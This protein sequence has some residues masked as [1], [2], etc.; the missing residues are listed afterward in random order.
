MANVNPVEIGPENKLVP[1]GVS[2]AEI[3]EP[4]DLFESCPDAVVVLDSA[5]TR[6]LGTNLQFLQLVGRDLTTWQGSPFHLLDCIHPDDH[7]VLM[8]GAA[9]AGTEWQ[10]SSSLRLI[11][12][13]N[14]VIPIE[15]HA[16][17]IGTESG[18][19]WIYFFRRVEE[20]RILE[21]RLKEEIEL[22]KR[23]TVEA[24]KSSLRIYQVTEK[25]RATPKL[26]TFLLDVQNEND[27]FE[28]ATEFL[29][30]EGLNYQEV[31]FFL[32]E[33]D[34]LQ[35]RHSTTE[36]LPDNVQL[37]KDGPYATFMR[38]GEQPDGNGDTRLVRIR[39]KDSVLGILEVLLD[40]REQVFF[41]ENTLV[42]RWHG[43]ILETI[44]EMLGLC[45]ENI[46]LYRELRVQSILDPLTGTYN[47]HFLLTQ[48]EKEI[49]RSQRSGR[50]LTMAFIDV[51]GFKEVN[52]T[53]GHPQGDLVLQQI[54]NLLRDSV[55]KTDFIC[56][57][58]G[59][60]FVVLLT[61]T[62]LAAAEAKAEQLRLAIEGFPFRAIELRQTTK[63]IRVTIS[64]GLASGNN[65]TAKRMLQVADAA[66]YGAKR[67][68]KNCVFLI[69]EIPGEVGEFQDA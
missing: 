18:V 69:K 62:D 39:T 19:R 23:R 11:N 52:D 53:F 22:Q 35:L 38:T 5:R 26:S 15:A 3:G 43:D 65:H 33:G 59:D 60:E 51:D 56:R 34:A 32:C 49:E 9:E 61:D 57:Y 24:V 6:T 20:R 12:D 28:R 54:A 2:L 1:L 13:A 45:L 50:P 27:L 63:A 67:Q 8:Q 55:R 48:L 25:M 66:L 10:G 37:G 31:A 14:E 41:A 21:S 46:R 4:L 29:R 44:A 42:E 64:V 47:R 58:G 30:S 17:R 36:R 68:G 16:R 40:P 7:P